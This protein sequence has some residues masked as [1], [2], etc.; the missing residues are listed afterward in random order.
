MV[1]NGG[2]VLNLKEL[3]KKNNTFTISQILSLLKE[4]IVSILVWTGIGL[5]FSLL[6]S[7]VFVD[8]KYS[9]NTEILVNQ[10]AS[11]D[12]NQQFS[13]QQADLQAIK[14]YKDILTKPFILSPV[15]KEIKQK[16]NYGGTMS[17]L[18]KSIEIDNQDNSQIISISV[19]DTNAYR[20]ADTANTIANVFT[21][22]IKL[23]MRVDNVHIVTKA[24]PNISPVFPNKGLNAFIGIVVG[25]TVGILIPILKKIFNTTLED[26]SFIT[27][28][29]E[30][31]NLG[32]VYHIDNLGN[33]LHAVYVVDDNRGDY[34]E[35]K[36]RV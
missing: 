4:N 22:K 23:L 1:F 21:K 12:P 20:A 31:N 19:M 33:K 34:L 2:V 17:D 14:T 30:L 5:L 9:S 3:Q 27:D 15:L 18:K 7:F 11:K 32:A 16:S 35:R 26:S 13:A 25:L 6:I 10:K 29:L 28:T 8:S 36:H 24:T